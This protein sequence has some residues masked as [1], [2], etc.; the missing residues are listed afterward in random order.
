MSPYLAIPGMRGGLESGLRPS[1]G[2]G[3]VPKL[4]YNN[5]LSIKVPGTLF[6]YPNM[7]MGKLMNAQEMLPQSSRGRMAHFQTAR[8]QGKSLSKLRPYFNIF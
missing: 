6:M 2:M 7:Q 5:D 1:R 3:L 8:A 4:W